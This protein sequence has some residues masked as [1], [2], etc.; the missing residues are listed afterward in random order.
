MSDHFLKQRGIGGSTP[1]SSVGTGNE[2]G[3]GAVEGTL[4]EQAIHGRPRRDFRGAVQP[5]LASRSLYHTPIEAREEY[6][7]RQAA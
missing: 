3:G 5:D 1:A 4:K 2:R 7:L 6:E